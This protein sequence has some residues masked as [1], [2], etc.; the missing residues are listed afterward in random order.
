MKILLDHN[1][2]KKLGPKLSEHLVFTARQMGWDRIEDRLLI[3]TSEA[4][5]FE[6]LITADKKMYSQQNHSQRKISLVV[7]DNN[8]MNNLE[9]K[10]DAIRAAVSRAIPGSYDFVLIPLSPK[11]GRIGAK[12]SKKQS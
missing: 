8:K 5:G 6:V 4:N 7:L 3:A 11:R 9:P 12:T 2:P 10:L 1:L